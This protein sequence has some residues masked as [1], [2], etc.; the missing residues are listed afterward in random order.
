MFSRALYTLGSGTAPLP[1]SEPA[2]GPASCWAVPSAWHSGFPPSSGCSPNGPSDFS[3]NPDR[4]PRTGLC[5]SAP[6]LS[7]QKC[8]SQLAWEVTTAVL[9]LI[10]RDHYLSSFSPFFWASLSYWAQM[11]TRHDLAW[12]LG[13]TNPTV[14]P[15]L[16]IRFCRPLTTSP[17]YGS[18]S[19]RAVPP[20]EL[21]SLSP[22]TA[23][24]IS[25]IHDLLELTDAT[26]HR[27]VRAQLCFI[28]DSDVTSSKMVITNLQVNASTV[29]RACE[30]LS[31]QVLDGLEGMPPVSDLRSP[32]LQSSWIF[33]SRLWLSA[34]RLFT[35]VR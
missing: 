13:A 18:S 5:G 6:W 24:S 19:R 1:R 21:W 12:D 25:V 34:S 27:L 17:P 32:F 28:L 8:L 11:S 29:H 35:L 30:D 26:L 16:E 33:L 3:L 31:P 14:N 15:E 23:G 4:P 22:A 2:L 10:G 7:S 20:W 9:S